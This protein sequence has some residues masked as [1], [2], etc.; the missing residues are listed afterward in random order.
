MVMYQFKAEKSVVEL[1]NDLQK[2][3]KRQHLEERVMTRIVKK[4]AEEK[5]KVGRGQLYITIMEEVA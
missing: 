5:E 2:L 1:R 3:V 4:F